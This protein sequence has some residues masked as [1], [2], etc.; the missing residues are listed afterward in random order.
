MASSGNTY[1]KNMILVLSHNFQFHIDFMY[2]F[3]DII[4]IM[5]LKGIR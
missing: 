2:S 3:S 4:R 1:V 5:Q